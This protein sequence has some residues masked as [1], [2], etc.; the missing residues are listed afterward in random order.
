MAARCSRSRTSR[1]ASTPTT[2]HVHAVDRLSFTLGPGRG[3]RHRRRVGLRQE[4]DLHVARPA[5][6]RDRG[7]QRP[8]RCSTGVDLLALSP[9][10][11]AP[12]ARPRDLVRLPGADDLAQPG[13][14]GRPADRRGAAEAPRPVR[15]ATRATRTIELL[16]L[17]RIPAPERRLDEYPHQLSGGMRQRVMIAMALACDPKVLIADEPTTALDVTIQAGILDLMRDIRERLGTAIVLITHN[18]GVVADIADR[19]LVM[20]A[21]RKAEEAPVAELFAAAAAPVHDRPAR[22]DPAA[23]RGEDAGAGCARSPAACR[24]CASCRRRAPSPSA[25]R[26]PTSSRARSA[27]AARASR[28]TTSSPASTRGRNDAGDAAPALEVVDLVKHYRVGARDHR[29]RRG[30]ARGRRRLVRAAARARCSASSASPGSGKSTVANCVL[31]LVEPTAGD[32]PAERHRHHAPLAPRAAAAAARA[33]H[34]LPGPVLVAQPAHDVRRHRRRA[35]AAAPAR[36]ADASSTRAST[37]MF[38]TVGLRTELRHRYPHELSGGQRQRVGPRARADPR[39]ERARRRRAGLGAR[40]LGA[41]VD[42]E[43][44]ARP[45]AATRLLVPLH[46]ARPRRRSSSSATASP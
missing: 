43:P 19:V 35:A 28:P 45:P 1:S 40:R 46:H 36:A 15:G 17:V 25:A 42:P 33:A 7:D 9:R 44:A 38:D 4:R 5:A 8:R 10:A 11:P 32:D 22:R 20:Y 6:A 18:L 16:R 31:R 12:G 13:V 2:G 21:G 23:V 34:R 30:R 3:A 27:R 26:A 41:G 37:Q 29:R 39:A 24:R 14:H